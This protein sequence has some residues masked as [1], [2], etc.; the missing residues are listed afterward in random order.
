MKYSHILT[1]IFLFT[2][3]T[4]SY[5]QNILSIGVK[6]YPATPELRFV[7]SQHIFRSKSTPIQIGRKG[8]SGVLLISAE[9]PF[10]TR[11]NISGL[12]YLYLENGDILRLQNKIGSDYVD[13]R[14]FALYSIT[15][16][17]I[18]KLK[19][20]NISKI[21]FTYTTYLGT[22]KGLTAGSYSTMPR[23][24]LDPPIDWDVA[25]I[26]SKIEVKKLF[27]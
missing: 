18:D 16:S 21:R 25:K 20:S 6:S 2:F 1:F 3:G 24:T 17:D 19:F 26:E 15:P 22:S 14:I 11:C 4:N 27:P 8:D 9:S 13:D 23:S 10:D 12:I 7:L 5:S